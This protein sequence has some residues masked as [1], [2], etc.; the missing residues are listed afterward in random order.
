M[1]FGGF[2]G[3]LANLGT[4]NSGMNQGLAQG[5]DALLRW[6]AVQQAQQQQQAQ[7]LAFSQ[8]LQPP[9]QQ[10]GGPSGPAYSPGAVQNAPLPQQPSPFPG[11][12]P[13]GFPT[14]M[15]PAGS[16][17]AWRNDLAGQPTMPPSPP[18]PSSPTPPSSQAGGF[19]DPGMHNQAGT[20]AQRSFMGM[21]PAMGASSIFDLA[22]RI[23]AT[24][25]LGTPGN[26]KWLALEKAAAVMA[27]GE[28][29]AFQ[30][31]MTGLREQHRQDMLD[32][33]EAFRERMRNEPPTP[34]QQAELKLRQTAESRE[35]EN[36]K[37]LASYRKTM[38]KVA[39][40]R[41]Q[42]AATK[43]AEKVNAQVA[44][45]RDMANDA[46]D[47]AAQI[48]KHPE[49]V[50]VRGALGRARESVT[51]QT[52][53]PLGGVDP[54]KDAFRAKLNDLQARAR[55]PMADSRYFS[56][57]AKELMSSII[58]GLRPFDNPTY[59]IQS[60]KA[61]EETLSHEADNLEGI[62]HSITSG[63]QKELENVIQYDAEGNRIGGQ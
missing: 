52:G 27:P 58:P 8:F 63:T 10:Q 31:M 28:R 45:L 2:L 43:G 34:Y 32:Q 5:S 30:A 22:R 25:P 35:A 21:P 47:L 57:A 50:G 20:L 18:P 59:T 13:A 53:L 46:K 29:M 15:N 26:V 51:E 17:V 62:A 19:D 37:S 39:G 55:R 54:E 11:G 49:W 40:D 33:Q 48:E 24:A 56:K 7:P 60:L 38:E 12:P 16:P 14:R 9:Q 36:Q 3:G 1:A 44:D 61:A 4:I 6:L 42:Q 23:E 41:V